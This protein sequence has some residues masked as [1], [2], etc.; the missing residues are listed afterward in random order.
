MSKFNVTKNILD[1]NN[2]IGNLVI[3]AIGDYN[4]EYEEKTGTRIPNIYQH[5]GMKSPK[6]LPDEIE[7][8]ITMQINGKEV[9]FGSYM[10]CLEATWGA[11]VMKQAQD[12]IHEKLGDKLIDI[13]YKMEQLEQSIKDKLEYK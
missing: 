1:T 11:F 9:P 3:S 12:L 13:Q 7:C 6:N 4:K 10:K 8:E 5:F 2:F